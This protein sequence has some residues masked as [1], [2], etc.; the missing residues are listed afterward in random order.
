MTALAV[1]MIIASVIGILPICVGYNRYEREE[2]RRLRKELARLSKL[3]AE[4]LRQEA[5]LAI[6]IV[7]Y[8][9]SIQIQTLFN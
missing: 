1:G 2:K 5:K 3:E 7:S 6:M 8:N 9:L 4:R